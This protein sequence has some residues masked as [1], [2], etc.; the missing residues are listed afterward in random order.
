MVF[1]RIQIHSEVR[2]KG[3]L[4]HTVPFIIVT[5]ISA[6]GY[7]NGHVDGVPLCIWRSR[8]RCAVHFRHQETREPQEACGNRAND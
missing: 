1:F 3:L 5:G 4:K 8:H 6:R 2:K 7:L